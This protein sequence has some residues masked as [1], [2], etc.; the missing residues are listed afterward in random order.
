MR[1][2]SREKAETRLVEEVALKKIDK[3]LSSNDTVLSR[4]FN[5]DSELTTT[6]VENYAFVTGKKTS[7]NSVKSNFQ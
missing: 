2:V 4:R 3:E 6:N 5:A 1:A 7:Q